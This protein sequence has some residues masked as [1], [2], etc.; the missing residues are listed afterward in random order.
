[1]INRMLFLLMPVMR[2]MMTWAMLATSNDE[3]EGL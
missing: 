1:M 3:Q 2:M